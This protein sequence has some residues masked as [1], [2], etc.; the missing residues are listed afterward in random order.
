MDF[1][2]V[3]DTKQSMNFL[4]IPG[5]ELATNH[6]RIPGQQ[7]A[8]S[9]TVPNQQSGA[10]FVGVS[11]QS[12]TKLQTL[13]HSRS[14]QCISNIATNA[15][16]IHLERRR[17]S[18]LPDITRSTSIFMSLDETTYHP[19]FDVENLYKM[20]DFVLVLCGAMFIISSIAYVVIWAYGFV[21]SSS[22]IFWIDNLV[23][24]N[25]NLT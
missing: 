8:M 20:T 4:Q 18:F 22:R 16:N 23:K 6:Q 13:Q 7:T 11:S 3:P 25:T 14:L 2:Q 1:L 24:L 17:I 5:Q 21:E 15:A 19:G 12:S 9:L 10:D